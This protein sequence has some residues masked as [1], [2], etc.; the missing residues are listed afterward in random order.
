MRES[1]RD[2]VDMVLSDNKQWKHDSEVCGFVQNKRLK[3][4]EFICRKNLTRADDSLLDQ[5]GFCHSSCSGEAEFPYEPCQNCLKQ[6]KP[7]TKKCKKAVDLC[8]NTVH[9][10]TN[11]RYFKQSP[12][13]IYKIQNVVMDERKRKQKIRWKAKM[14]LEKLSKVDGGDE[15]DLDPTKFSAD[16]L[17]DDDLKKLINDHFDDPDNVKDDQIQKYIFE[18]CMLN[19][20][21]NLGRNHA[22]I[23]FWLFNMLLL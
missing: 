20:K 3:K 16:M 21:R 22:D 13:M 14:K 6:S 17:F 9:L 15:L 5:F 11:T 12:G 2:Y 18:E 8:D 23:L 7:I 10:K 1:I 19:S 4:S